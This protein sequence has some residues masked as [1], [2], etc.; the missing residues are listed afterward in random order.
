MKKSV[1]KVLSVILTAVMVFALLPVLSF[2]MKA[3]AEKYT[4][5]DGIFDYIIDENNQITI[6]GYNGTDT[7]LVI[8]EEIDGKPVCFINEA[9][10]IYEISL[11]SVVFKAKLESIGRCAFAYCVN[12]ESV[13]FEGDVGYI[14]EY[15]FSNCVSL[16]T[17]ILNGNIRTNEKAFKNLPNYTIT[18]NAVGGVL[19]ISSV[20]TNYKFK[21]DVLPI[22]SYEGYQFKGWFTSAVGGDEITKDTEFN[23]NQIVYAHWEW[24][25]HQAQDE[26]VDV[27]E[28]QAHDERADNN[29]SCHEGWVPI[30]SATELNRLFSCGGSGYLTNDIE[31]RLNT[32]LSSGDEVNLCLNGYSITQTDNIPCFDDLQGNFNLYDKIDNSGIITHKDN[33]NDLGVYVYKGTFTMNGGTITGNIAGNGTTSFSSSNYRGGG[34]FVC[35][36]KFIM[37]GGIISNNTA[38]D[39]GGVYVKNGTFIMNDGTITNNEANAKNFSRGGGVCVFDGIFTMNE[40]TIANNSSQL[41]G[42][43]HSNTFIM[44]GGTISNNISKLYG[45]GIYSSNFTMNEG[46]ITGN[47]SEQG[48][49]VYST[50]FAMNEGTITDNSSE[51]GGGVYSSLFTMNG[52]N[53][54]NNKDNTDHNEVDITPNGKIVFAG[55]NIAEINENFVKVIFNSN[56]GSSNIV[57][58]YQYKNKDVSLASN[59]FVRDGYDFMA[60]N[61]SCDRSGKIYNDGELINIDSDLILYSQWKALNAERYNVTFKVKNGSWE[62]GTIEDKTVEVWRN[63]DE[64]FGLNLNPCSIPIVGNNPKQGFMVGSWEN[65]PSTDTVINENK[66]F[67]YIYVEDPDATYTISFDSNDGKTLTT[68]LETGFDHKVASLP[69]PEFREGYDFAGWFTEKTGGTEVTT[70]TVFT[71]DSTVYAQWNAHSYKVQFDANGGSGAMDDQTRE[72]DDG[73]VLSTNAFTYEGRTFNGWNTAADGT[74]TPYADEEEGNLSSTD[75]D[76]VTLYAQWTTDTFTISWK[77]FNGTLLETDNDV[78]YGSTPSYDGE[79]PTRAQ[80]GNKKY[81]FSGWSPEVS[82]VTGAATYTATYSEEEIVEPTET[83]TPEEPQE[84]TKQETPEEPLEPT[85][86]T[87]PEPIEPTEPEIPEEPEVIEPELEIPEKDWL[88]DLRLTLR[89]ADE[90]GG[91]QTVEYSGDFALSYDIMTYLVEHPSITFIYHVKYEDVEYTIIIPAGKAVS[92]PEIPWYGPLWLLANYGN[93]NVP[94]A[95]KGTN[96]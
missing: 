50:I 42:G 18:F 34:V 5:S 85:E 68:T 79:T 6:T 41:G 31:G 75:G 95:Q 60:W 73:A 11:K 56:D 17:L 54:F 29:C 51:Q 86:P 20:E 3:K 52:G 25:E 89:I 22:P 65:N 74:G 69:A 23:S 24:K 72:Y 9:A 66:T 40:G 80:E 35:E 28:H 38:Q 61:T 27:K 32:F 2:P 88:D 91:A 47:S 90:L 45:G 87:E 81:T 49:G 96:E 8:P 7:N 4:S 58:Q 78:A 64:N 77:N 30:S 12:L 46:T 93:G 10:F 26:L 82:T 92:S 21:L 44:N 37:N 71:S 39:G 67:T 43:I 83:E 63:N 57:T 1:R 76:I 33:C 15:V 48:G 55:G 19:N 16:T 62:D 70:D 84:P 94:Q 13:D 59:Q 14:D 53:V 36:G